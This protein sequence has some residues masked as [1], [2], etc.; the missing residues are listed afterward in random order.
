MTTH[1]NPT[2]D[3]DRIAMC[4]TPRRLKLTS[5]AG[6]SR[7]SA[8]T[9]SMRDAVYRPEFRQDSTAVSTISFMAKAA[10]GTFIAAKA[11][12]NGESPAC[13]WFHGTIITISEMDP[14]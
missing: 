2:A 13:I 9:N 5:R 3:E 6:A 14:T 11:T 4:G 12:A 8:S 10:A 7:R 1:R